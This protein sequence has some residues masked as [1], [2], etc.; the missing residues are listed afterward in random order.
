[1]AKLNK[2]QLA[3][4]KTRAKIIAAATKLWEQPGSFDTVSVRDIAREAKMSTGAIFAN[5]S[6][7][8][9]LW[10]EVMGYPAPCDC[11][12]VREV[13]K[14]LGGSVSGKEQPK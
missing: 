2:R 4:A 12:E 5:F 3:K 1:M 8:Q 11:A 14:A 13:M 7:V 10:L 9:E 6:G